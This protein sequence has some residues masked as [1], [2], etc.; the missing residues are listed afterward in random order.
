MYKLNYIHSNMCM[1][2]QEVK[3]HHIAQTKIQNIPK[4]LVMFINIASVRFV[5]VISSENINGV[6]KQ[7]KVYERN[8]V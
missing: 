6:Y 7:C 4:H 2:H 1:I 3:K 8:F 5:N